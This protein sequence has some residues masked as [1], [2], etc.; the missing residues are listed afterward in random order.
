METVC[1]RH[2]SPGRVSP[3]RAASLGLIQPLRQAPSEREP[4]PGCLRDRLG[5]RSERRKAGEIS[6]VLVGSGQIAAWCAQRCAPAVLPLTRKRKLGKLPL[7]RYGPATIVRLSGVASGKQG[8]SWLTPLGRVPQVTG[9]PGPAAVTPV[10]RGPC[11]YWRGCHIHAGRGAWLGHPRRIRAGPAG[12]TGHTRPSGSLA[13]H[14][15]RPAARPGPGGGPAGRH[16]RGIHGP[17]TTPTPG[18]D[19]PDRP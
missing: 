12:T 19:L 17:R 10:P 18:Q 14:R 16:E 11:P 15:S 3:R 6:V 8:A 2:G 13:Y 1:A 5:R 4:A 9:E 7:H